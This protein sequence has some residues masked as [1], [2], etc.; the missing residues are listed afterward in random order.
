MRPPRFAPCPWNKKMTETIGSKTMIPPVPPASFHSACQ[1]DSWKSVHPGIDP[2]IYGYST[3]QIR[4]Q[5]SIFVRACDNRNPGFRD[6]SRYRYSPCIFSA[7]LLVLWGNY[8]RGKANARN[9]PYPYKNQYFE[10]V[11][12]K[13]TSFFR[14]LA[15]F[16]NH[17]TMWRAMPAPVFVCST[18]PSVSRDRHYIEFWDQGGAG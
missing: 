4:V 8:Y 14:T 17:I 9:G 1:L 11:I 6:T 7:L 2:Y 18:E 3:D 16:V 15:H 5:I 12:S 13:Y 10:T